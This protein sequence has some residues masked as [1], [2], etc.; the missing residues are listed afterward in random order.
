MRL[1][2]ANEKEGKDWGPLHT[3][4][5][6]RP[7]PGR[8]TRP[9]AP[10]AQ[11]VMPLQRMLLVRVQA[12]YE[13]T[14][15]M[16]I[17]SNRLGQGLLYTPGCGYNLHSYLRSVIFSS[18]KRKFLAQTPQKCKPGVSSVPQLPGVG[19]IVR[20]VR[21]RYLPGAEPAKHM[22]LGLMAAHTTRG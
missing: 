1:A 22:V 18:R 15:V 11:R 13:D 3:V 12:V 20:S 6:K 14:Y 17:L 5:R 8:R 9:P 10:P 2:A 4:P 19:K 16:S 21:E 7:R